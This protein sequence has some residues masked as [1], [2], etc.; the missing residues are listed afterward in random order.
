M[1][2]DWLNIVRYTIHH[3]LINSQCIQFDKA[4]GLLCEVLQATIYTVHFPQ[5]ICL[6]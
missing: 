2:L 5:Y 4:W 6:A 3:T 1:K